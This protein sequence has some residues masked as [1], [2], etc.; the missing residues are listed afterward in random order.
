M[1]RPGPGTPV[2]ARRSLRSGLGH[3]LVIAS[4]P[5]VVAILGVLALNGMS[6]TASSPGTSRARSSRRNGLW[7]DGG[8]PASW[9]DQSASPKRVRLVADPAGGQDRVLELIAYN[10]DTAPLT[11]TQNPRAQ[12]VTST[13]IVERD[14]PFWE[15]YQVYV[16]RTFP[17]AQTY[18]GWLT[19]GSPFYGRPFNGTPSV[20][21]TISD[22]DFV[23]KGNSHAP[24]PWEIFW[25]RPVVTGQW[26]R[27]TWHVVPRTNGFV[28]LYVDGAPVHVGGNEYGVHLPVIDPSNDTGPWFSQLSVYFRHNE[29]SHLR[30]YFRDFKIGSTER[31][32][33]G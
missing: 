4:L 2:S 3:F 32:V 22:G 6:R 24:T 30:L 17:V 11:P 7:F 27:F 31:A 33:V 1:I 15:S 28:E 18:G 20:D 29:F 26:I 8:R 9:I 16:P 13:G 12:L 25:H 19:L 10:G 5:A 14:Q 21:L 23:W